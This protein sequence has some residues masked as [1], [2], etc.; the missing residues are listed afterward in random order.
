MIA[1]TALGGALYAAQSGRDAAATLNSSQ[2]SHG[3]DSSSDHA[4][5]DNASSHG[6]SDNRSSYGT[7]GYASP[8]PSYNAPPPVA[9]R[10]SSGNDGLLLGY[11]LGRSSSPREPVIVQQPTARAVESSA[12]PSY[13]RAPGDDEAPD[14][15]IAASDPGTETGD[16]SPATAAKP[17]AGGSKH[18]ILDAFLLIG[19]LFLSGCLVVALLKRMRRAWL[20]RK[21]RYTSHTN[22]RL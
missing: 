16:Q 20:V 9:A 21:A 18:P 1:A 7:R 3:S 22:Y 2:S 6:T 15:G 4:S 11:M 17:P 19:M 8:P 14:T 13:H 5:S 12:A 10:Q